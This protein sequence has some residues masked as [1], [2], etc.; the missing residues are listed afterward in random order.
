[1]ENR[2]KFRDLILRIAERRLLYA[3]G[4]TGTYNGAI[5][6]ITDFDALMEEIIESVLEDVRSGRIQLKRR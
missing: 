4:I 1:M 3:N 2:Q 6:F 5:D